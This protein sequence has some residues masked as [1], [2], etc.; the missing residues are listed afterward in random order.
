MA[1][2]IE[3]VFAGNS[4]APQLRIELVSFS[5]RWCAAVERPIANVH[6]E[7]LQHGWR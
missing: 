6:I 5:P 1:Q 7:Q 2:L 4:D 3:D